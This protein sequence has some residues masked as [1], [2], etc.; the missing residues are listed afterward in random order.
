V[1]QGRLRDIAAASLRATGLEARGMKNALAI[2]RTEHTFFFPD[3]PRAFDGYRLLHLTDL[4]LGFFPGLSERVIE[5]A[6]DEADLCVMTGD[7][8]AHW[9]MP[10]DRVIAALGRVV[11][12][13][14]AP[15]GIVAVLGNH[16]PASLAA[17]LSDMG[18][19]VLVNR[20]HAVARGADR[21]TFVGVDD[22]RYHRTATG[23]AALAGPRDGFSIA[24]IHSPRY[25]AEAGRAGIALYLCGHTHA[26]QVCLPG[27]VAVWRPRECR[28]R[29]AGRWRVKGMQGFTSAGAGV[30][31]LPVRFNCPGEV[32]RITLRRGE[33]P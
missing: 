9:R 28:T 32:A 33:G 3:L 20:R 24:L 22:R 11:G 5:L 15:D 26:G 27:A 1:I 30:S 13:V 6:A 19:T 23:R 17:P 21:L 10:M 16:D 8:R 14:R 4:H 12:A 7:Y 31:L 25:A 29:M 18:A 2:R